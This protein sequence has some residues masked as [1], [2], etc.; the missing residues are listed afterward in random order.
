MQRLKR[1]VQAAC[2]TFTI[3]FLAIYATPI[4][5]WYAA[6]LTGNWTDSDG[7]VL[8]V[9][10]AEAE[11]GDIIGLSS[12]WRAT[13]AIR[14]WRSGHF[15]A[16]V[17]SGGHADGLDQPLAAIIG[18]FLSSNGIPQD[19]IFIEP[20]SV[21]T[22]ENAVFT[23]RMI[24]TW[25]GKKVLLTSDYHMFRARRAFETAGLAVVPRPFPDVIKQSESL[26]YRGPCFW[27]LTEETVKIVVYWWRGWIRA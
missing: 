27:T 6:R 19:K 9:L 24:G 11:P 7:D 13:Y 14:A 2:V 18:R 17:V 12:Y 22:R 8:I 25:P 26:L 16:V 23:Q 4:T 10:A 15:R 3:L 20:H 5:R 21:S 1:W